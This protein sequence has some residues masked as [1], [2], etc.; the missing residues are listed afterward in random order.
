[1]RLLIDSHAFIW[2][3]DDVPRLTQAAMQDPA[4]ELFLSAASIWEM[5]IKVSVRKMTL[6]LPYRQWMD[7]A[8]CDLGLSILPITVDYA[9]VCA[10]LPW[11]HRD[12]F[13]RLLIAQAQ[14]EALSV[15]SGDSQLD[16]Y[17]ITRIW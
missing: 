4:N 13:D 5:A 2:A 1:M 10:G 12:P 9:E 7:K 16:A 6:S 15:V 17:S 3:V 14:V 8:I 11:H